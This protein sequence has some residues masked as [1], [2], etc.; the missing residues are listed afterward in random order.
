[1]TTDDLERGLITGLKYLKLGGQTLSGGQ[2]DRK[3]EDF[4]SAGSLR[5]DW[6][7]EQCDK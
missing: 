4:Y 1:M 3:H 2:T 6:Y 5:M 7:G